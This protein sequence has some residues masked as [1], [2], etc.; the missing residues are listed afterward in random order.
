V[1]SGL[2]DWIFILVSGVY[3]ELAEIIRIRRL[4]A[5]SSASEMTYIVSSGALNSTHSLTRLRLRCVFL[6]S[7]QRR[8]VKTMIIEAPARCERTRRER[9]W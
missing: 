4:L 8:R 9:K 3:C 2:N 7:R 5:S 1:R 6:Q